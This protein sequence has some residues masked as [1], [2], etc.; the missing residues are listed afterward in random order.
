MIQGRKSA[1]VRLS[2]KCD[3]SV[4]PK[5]PLCKGVRSHAFR[6]RWAAERRLGGIVPKKQSNF[7]FFRK[8]VYF[9][10]PSVKNHRFL[11]APLG[12]KGSL[13]R[14]RAIRFF[15][16]LKLP[17]LFRAGAIPIVRLL[18]TATPSLKKANRFQCLR[19]KT[20]VRAITHP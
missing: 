3:F 15:D 8:D 18:L 11:T 12:H 17:R 14:S 13:G 10:I 20:P 6:L 4:A 9:S 1:P 7:R 5:P 2:K 19:I 16:S